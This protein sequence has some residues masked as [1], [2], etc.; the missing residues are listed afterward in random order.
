M[1]HEGD[2]TRAI[3]STLRGMEDFGPSALLEDVAYH[4]RKYGRSIDEDELVDILTTVDVNSQEHK[5]IRGNLAKWDASGNGDWIRATQP[6]TSERRALVLRLLG[7]TPEAAARIDNVHPAYLTTDVT[8]ADP[9]WDPWYTAERR[10]QN[11]FYWRAYERVLAEKLDPDAVASIDATTSNVVSRLADPLAIEPYQAKGLVVGHV[12]SGKTANFTGVIAKAIDAGYRLVIV[13]TGT[14]EL[15]RSQ[16]QRRLDMELIGQENI[17]G[18][19]D[20]ND[21]HAIADIDYVGDG[22]LDWASGKFVKHGIDF[23]MEPGVP[24]VRR[25]T[26][27][28]VDYKRLAAGLDALDFRS[29]NELRNPRQPVWHA[30]NLF[31]TDVRIAVVKKNKTVLTKLVQ[32]LKNV[33]ANL[34]EIPT[35]IIDDEA[36]Q[37]SVNTTNPAK[38]KSKDQVE[39]S[40]I[41]RL[42]AE[43]LGEVKRSQYVGYTA[44]P[45]ANVFV[46]PEDAEDIFPKDFIISLSPPPTYMGGQSFHD[47]NGLEDSEVG[48]PAVSNAAA[49]VRDLV[50][51][52]EVGVAEELRGAL[53]SF[54]L[55]GALK[56]WREEHVE[57]LSFKHHT[58]LVHE[59]VK[60]AEHKELAALIRRVWSQAAYSSP[61]AKAR[62]RELFETDFAAVSRSR[63]TW[64]APLPGDFEEIS[65]HIGR[66]LDL[67]MNQGDPVIVV[68]GDKE[69]EYEDVN[70]QKGR[71]WRVLIGGTKLSRG[72]TV[73]GLTVTY[74]RR[75]AMAADT[76]M[77][78]GRWFGY[79]PGFQDLVR[80]YIARNAIGPG[81]REFDLYDAF[82]AIIQDEEEFRAQLRQFSEVDGD[83][84]PMIRP[85][86][87]PPL[88]FQQLPW[89]R[90]TSRNKMFNAELDFMG[91]GGQLKDYPRQPERGR[92]EH[93]ARHFEAV[94]PW[95]QGLSEVKVFQYHDAATEKT[96]T[97]LGRTTL[98]SADS[99]LTALSEFAWVEGFDFL[100][101]LSMLEQAMA[102][103]SLQDWAVLVPYL[104]KSPVLRQVEGLQV[105]VLR[106]ARRDGSR[107]GF[108]GSSF[109]QRDAVQHI[110][111][112]PDKRGGAAAQALH[113][114][115]RGAMLLTFAADPIPS[116][117]RRPESLG[118]VVKSADI[119][120][121]FS[122][123]LPKA[124]APRG[125]VG[126]RVRNGAHPNEAIV[127]DDD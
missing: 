107:G 24:A 71:V 102:E 2:Y 125:R 45:F 44:T 64:D 35:L 74:Y 89:L 56:L 80:L 106:R 96:G 75:R 91:E 87:V 18:G 40:A 41:N 47:L 109:R 83:G 97:F 17:L 6:R 70:F 5:A 68:N 82:E 38:S 60:Q 46:S 4:L 36:D 101:T 113:T 11:D 78:M 54:V 26:G 10:R 1:V 8:I 25:L 62:L 27:Q 65:A 88:V 55:T 59:S 93:N 100:P 69:S 120:T 63:P 94:R 121:L 124:A 16:T 57:G 66:V 12:Q 76:L 23:G 127:T 48:D 7:F 111:G 28:A 108:S 51:T 32:D 58:M 84:E 20:E 103:N 13:L 15:L 118:Q 123:V 61:Q 126:F 119:A 112:N 33:K 42:I 114:E 73:E 29:G 49:F 34:N 99:M 86:Q 21:P 90:P 3:V 22:D 95:L 110:A 79:R 19:R 116:A 81:G 30:D 72:F 104:G 92:G 31:D 85:I 50:A 77:Q 117:D 14:V 43:L 105:P 52:E 67:V 122:L 98:V 115:T 37:A 53:D 39:R 9:N